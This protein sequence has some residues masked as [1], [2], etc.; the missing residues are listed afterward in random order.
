MTRF[1]VYPR[2]NAPQY[3]GCAPV[4]GPLV[5]DPL[6]LQAASVHLLAVAVGP[7]RSAEL[8]VHRIVG[9]VA[10]DTY[11]HRIQ[12]AAHHA[13]SVDASDDVHIAAYTHPA[14]AGYTD[15]AVIHIAW[16]LPFVF[17]SLPSA[18]YAGIPHRK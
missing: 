1:S 14:V 17:A 13:A 7:E 12:A 9:H 6:G 5:I 2:L 10:V 18:F 16:P 4:I 3:H 8:A 11:L 15:I